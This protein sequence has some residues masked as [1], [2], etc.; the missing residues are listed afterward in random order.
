MVIGGLVRLVQV[1]W[2]AV[3][4]G[5]LQAAEPRTMLQHDHNDQHDEHGEQRHAREQR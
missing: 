5:V 1:A 3:V 4:N 2:A